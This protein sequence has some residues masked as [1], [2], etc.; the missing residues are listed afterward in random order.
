MYKR[1]LYSKKLFEVN[2]GENLYRKV[3]EKGLYLI[4]LDHHLL[5][6]ICNTQNPQGIVGII[7]QMDYSLEDIIK[8]DVGTIILLN[9]LQDPGNLGTIV[10][11]ADAAGVDGVVPVSYTHLDVYKR[12]YTNMVSSIFMFLSGVNFVIYYQL[13]QRN[14]K[15]AFNNEEL[16][17]Y[18]III[19]V[20]VIL[21]AINL[22]NKLYD[23][24]LKTA[25]HAT[26]QVIS[27]ITTT[28]YITVDLNAWTDFSKFILFMLMF[29]GPCSGSIGGGLKN[30]R[31]LIL[32]KM[33]KREFLKIFHPRACL[34]YTSRCV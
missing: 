23:N 9:E 11:T 8:N 4:E 1:Q 27:F 18:I 3:L 34:L 26:F 15:E 5:K 20:S 19:V 14:W 13:F 10:R 24:V 6:G 16:R 29:I 12:Q 32:L 33:V 25:E 31:I 17:L 22:N 21:I 30:I 2:G 7:E 28:G